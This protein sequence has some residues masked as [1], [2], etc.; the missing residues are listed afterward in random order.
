MSTTST[1]AFTLIW[2]LG[3]AILVVALFTLLGKKPASRRSARQAVPSTAEKAPAA[4]K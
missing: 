4:G 3:G 2:L 1:D